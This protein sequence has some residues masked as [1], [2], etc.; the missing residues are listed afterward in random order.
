MLN[1][2]VGLVENRPPPSMIRTTGDHVTI[3][4]ASVV[5]TGPIRKNAI[6]RSTTAVR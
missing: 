5:Q 3:D 4:L 6:R 1:S 2:K